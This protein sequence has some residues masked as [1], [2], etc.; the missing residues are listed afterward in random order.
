MPDTP[1]ALV[2]CTELMLSRLPE[3]APVWNRR[4]ERSFAYPKGTWRPPR[5]WCL[6]FFTD[7]HDQHA[8]RAIIGIGSAFPGR[9]S[10][11]YERSLIVK[12]YAPLQRPLPLGELIEPMGRSRSYLSDDGRMSPAAGKALLEGVRLLRPEIANTLNQLESSLGANPPTGEAGDRL[13]LEKDSVGLLLDFAGMDRD[14][15]ETW[16]APPNESSLPSVPFLSGLPDLA[17]I[18]D[19]QIVDD[20]MRFPGLQ[21]GDAY[22]RDWRVFTRDRNSENPHRLFVYNANRTRI[23]TGMGVDLIYYNEPSQSFTMIQYKRMRQEGNRWVYRRDPNIDRELERMRDVDENC[24]KKD[25]SL[26]L[27]LVHT[28]CLVKL[29]RHEPFRMNSSSL[30]SGMYLTREHFEDLLYSP[31]ATGPKGGVRI[32]EEE[33]P[34]YL[35]NTTAT[36]LIK[37]GWIGSRGMGT[38]FVA[39]YIRRALSRGSV[40]AGFH[41]GPQPMGNQRRPRF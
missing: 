16:Q 27:R 5:V 33:V 4:G 3:D 37:D 36:T 10:E 12:S 22:E 7:R 18:E 39:D 20:F 21:G 11:T 40:V 29:C 6:T 23:E 34:R 28:P 14:I 41:L 13:A 15:L 9:Q 38:E 17:T 2:R 24:M 31:S 35:N 1:V 19:Q 8:A 25:S 30:I 26:D 32:L